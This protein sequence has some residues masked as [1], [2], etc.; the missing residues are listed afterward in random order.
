M[1]K[2]ASLIRVARNQSQDREI[3]HLPLSQSWDQ[4][5]CP[6]LRR[7]LEERDWVVDDR[8][9]GGRGM[10]GGGFCGRGV[11]GCWNVVIVGTVVSQSYTG[12]TS[13]VNRDY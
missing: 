12:I 1:N 10:I 6:F 7:Q 2:F 13:T 11:I 9:L 3:E 5:I 8:G 4:N